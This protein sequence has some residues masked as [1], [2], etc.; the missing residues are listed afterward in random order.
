MI[1]VFP[2]VTMSVISSITSC[3]FDLDYQTFWEDNTSLT[4]E[5]DVYGLNTAFWEE[6]LPLPPRIHRLSIISRIAQIRRGLIKAP[7]IW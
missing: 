2:R 4:C 6:E 3:S 5:P 1:P 7:P